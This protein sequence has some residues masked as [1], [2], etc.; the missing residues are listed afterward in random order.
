MSFPWRRAWRHGAQASL[1]AVSL[2]LLLVGVF[3][4]GAP[5]SS[6]RSGPAGFYGSASFGI[7]QVNGTIQGSAEDETDRPLSG[8]T[9]RLFGAVD[10]TTTTNASGAFIFPEVPP[11]TYLLAGSKSGYLNASAQAE[12]VS[13]LVTNVTLR[14][15]GGGIT[16]TIRDAQGVLAG[17][18]ITV[19]GPGATAF[20]DAGGNYLIRGLPTSDYAVF[21]EKRG[22]LN[23]TRLVHVEAGV[24]TENVDFL[25]ESLLGAITGFVLDEDGAPL[26]GANVTVMLATGTLIGSADGLGAYHIQG[27]PRGNWTVTATKTGYWPNGTAGVV[28][29]RGVTTGPVNFTLQRKLGILRGN[30]TDGTYAIPGALVRLIGE[31]PLNATT[32]SRGA[33]AISGIP[34]GSYFVFVQKAG[35]GDVFSQTPVIIA[36]GD[37]FYQDFVLRPKE[38]I[39]NGTVTDGAIPISGAEIRIQGPGLS[40][41]EYTNDQGFFQRGGIPNGTYTVIVSAEGFRSR[42]FTVQV[43]EEEPVALRTI[44]LTPITTIQPTPGFIFGFDLPHS[45][46]TIGLIATILILALAAY[47]RLRTFVKPHAA[48]VEYEEEMA[49]PEAQQARG[50]EEGGAGPRPPP[51]AE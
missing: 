12:S 40:T 46:M 4:A 21:V 7:L 24:T 6:S 43:S 32:N 49:E 13:G 11:G 36:L 28:V 3:A 27:V 2:I 1:A 29:E 25:L 33:Y 9:V 50:A 15:Y 19:L 18:N 45:L 37:E 31:A 48:P 47:L 42:S 20:S 22:Y 8:V 44:V 38:G 10:R 17:A 30:I 51:P 26:P 23:A 39:L 5:L 14:L 16:G 34:P 41:V 35:F